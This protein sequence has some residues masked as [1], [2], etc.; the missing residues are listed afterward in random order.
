MGISLKNCNMTLVE[1]RPRSILLNQRNRTQTAIMRALIPP[2]PPSLDHL[3]TRPKNIY[4]A[5]FSFP[6]FKFKVFYYFYKIVIN[7]IMT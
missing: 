1:A 6:N 5:V 2:P 4:Y 7:K 3:T